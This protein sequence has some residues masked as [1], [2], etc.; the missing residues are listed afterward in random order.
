MSEAAFSVRVVSWQEAAPQLS[1]VRGTVFIDEQ[2][3]PEELEWDGEDESA[4]HV[5]ALDDWGVPIGTG[6][7]LAHGAQGHVGR[8]AVVKAWRGKG[9]GSGILQ[10]L[11]DAA[12]TRG[13][14]D[15]FLNAQTY[16]VPFYERFGF[17]CEGEEFL[18][19]GIPHHRMRLPALRVKRS[20]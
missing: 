13:C 10:T 14:T 19:A 3:V 20:L 8:M 18:D 5:L 11:L 7:L 17:V 4:I 12:H 16:A 1:T 6:R 2:H 15:L 9:V